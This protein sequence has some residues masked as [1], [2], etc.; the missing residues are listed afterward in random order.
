MGRRWTL[1]V[2]VAL[3]LLL[4]ASSATAGSTQGTDAPVRPN[5][6]VIMLDD[7]GALDGRLLRVLPSIREVFLERGVAFSDFHVETPLCCPGR[8]GFLTGQHTPNHG[9]IR[10]DVRLLDPR[11]T[12][13]TQL[14][15]V[16]YHTILAGKYLN[17][18]ARIAPRVPRGWDRFHALSN[19]AY[20][21]YSLWSNGRL[22]RH[23]HAAADY[24]TDVIARLA[25]R[26]IRSTPRTRPVFGWIAPFAAHV[27]TLPA[28]R[29]WADPRCASI[30]RWRPPNYMER[31][32]T[33]KPQYVRSLGRIRPAGYPLFRTCRS[34][35]AVDDLLG[36]VRSELR[37][38]RRLANTL[39]VLTSDNGMTYGEHRLFGEKKSPYA[40]HVPFYVSWPAMLGTRHRQ[41]EE[42]IQNIDFAQT[43]CALAGCRMGPYPGGQRR[44]DGR[45]FAGLLLGRSGRINRDAVYANYLDPGQWV[46][47]WH[48]VE[49]T[50]RSA[51]AE[52]GCLAA[53]SGGCRWAYVRYE[54][55]E[56]ELYDLSNGPCWTWRPG[57][58]GDPCRLENLVG[59][60]RYAS[61]ERAL[62]ARLRQLKAE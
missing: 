59:R 46:P 2:V 44:P 26:S 4:D 47:R 10:N 30:D 33:D 23:G 25:V 39:L 55:G 42:R 13:T 37:R 28:P 49:T 31:D 57:D 15:G 41:I 50:L 19:G 51:L 18:Y 61:I 22:E 43:M 5:I 48:G 60:P 34:L 27:P 12:L 36:R 52:Q 14:H 56:R 8:A 17:E 54:T 38:Q 6:V 24:S 16:G 35:L 40:T 53:E 7:V 21:D 58:P 1:G 62:R 9:V 32:A 45:S 3:L 29:H 20:Y 11:M